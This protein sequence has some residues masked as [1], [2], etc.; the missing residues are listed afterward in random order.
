MATNENDVIFDP[1][2]GVGSTGVAALQLNRKF[3]V[4]V[5][6]YFSCIICGNF[7]KNFSILGAITT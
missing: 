3:T 2:M 6:R 5:N 4:Q 1:F 7:L